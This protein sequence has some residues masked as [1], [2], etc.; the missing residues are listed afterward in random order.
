MPTFLHPKELCRKLDARVKD[1]G[2]DLH[3][4]TAE[5]LP[6]KC[7]NLSVEPKQLEVWE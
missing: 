5:T 1:F 2:G 4:E 3:Q 7:M 6:P